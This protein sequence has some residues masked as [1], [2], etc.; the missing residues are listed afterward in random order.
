ML[1][2]QEAGYYS[3]AVTIADYVLLLPTVVASILFPKLSTGMG[4]REKLRFVKRATIATNMILLPLAFVAVVASRPTIHAVFGPAFTPSAAALA[5][6]AP[7]ILA[8]GT[9]IV[10]VQFLNSEGYPVSVLVAWLVTT[11]LNI[12]LNIWAIPNY[13]IVG[14]SAVSSVTY[15]IMCILVVGIIL[16]RKYSVD[17]PKLSELVVES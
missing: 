3:V 2:I 17:H 6:L 13:G 12:T 4:F 1:G 15:S 16:A 9:E 7:G 14:A 8:L 11:I 5:W 10:A